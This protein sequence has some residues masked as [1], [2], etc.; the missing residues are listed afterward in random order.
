MKQP[1]WYLRNWEYENRVAP[2]GEVRRELVYR[3]E[4][5]RL[6]PDALPAGRLKAAYLALSLLLCADLGVLLTHVSRGACLFFVGGAA[7]LT[8]IPALYLAIGCFKALGA[9]ERMTYRDLRSSY[10]RIRTASKW[11][12]PLMSVCLAGELFYL[13]FRLANG[14]DVLWRTELPWLAGSALGAAVGA[15]ILLLLSRNRID[16]LPMEQ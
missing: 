12:L 4:Y 11:V 2:G 6:A 1:H 15:V 5:Y 10:L 14:L 3:G 9:P 13:V 16:V 7:A 8:L